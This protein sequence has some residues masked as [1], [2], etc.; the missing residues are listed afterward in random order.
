MSIFPPQEL[1]NYQSYL[2]YS[3]NLKLVEYPEKKIKFSLKFSMY[4]ITH[5]NIIKALILLIKLLSFS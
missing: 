3:S 5:K 1:V 2:K 4:P